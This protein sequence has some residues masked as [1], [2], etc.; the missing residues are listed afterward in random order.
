MV[1]VLEKKEEGREVGETWKG[2]SSLFPETALYGLEFLGRH[3][4]SG[5]EV[6]WTRSA[7]VFSAYLSEAN[8]LPRLVYI[9]ARARPRLLR[10]PLNNTSRSTYRQ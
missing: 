3:S 9:E 10:R 6:S 1:D 4:V 5:S 7:V 2:S 8:P